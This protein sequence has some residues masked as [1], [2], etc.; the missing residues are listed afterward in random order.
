MPDLPTRCYAVLPLVPILIDFLRKAKISADALIPGKASKMNRSVRTPRS[1]NSVQSQ[2]TQF[3]P[4]ITEAINQLAENL[5]EEGRMTL[6]Q[7]KFIYTSY[8]EDIWARVVYYII[9]NCEPKLIN[10]ETAYKMI[11]VFKQK[12]QDLTTKDEACGGALGPILD[13]IPRSHFEVLGAFCAYIRDCSR[14]VISVSK[15]VA[16]GVIASGSS[17]DDKDL[18]QLLVDKAEPIFGR[19]ASAKAKPRK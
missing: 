5:E 7:I 6:T 18:F 3:D 10:A 8:E 11:E 19:I 13:D 1:P 9:S 17:K 16:K 14:D 15:G 2:S 4:N 12:R